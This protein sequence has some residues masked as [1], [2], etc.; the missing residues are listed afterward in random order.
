MGV[1]LCEDKLYTIVTT[2]FAMTPVFAIDTIKL[3]SVVTKWHSAVQA[4]AKGHAHEIA[5]ERAHNELH[6]MM[7][8]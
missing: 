2:V 7:G 1:V 8:H 4:Q 3:P 6:R 5:A